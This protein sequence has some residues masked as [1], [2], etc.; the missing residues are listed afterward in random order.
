MLRVLIMALAIVLPGSGL[1]ACDNSS[2]ST[3]SDGANRVTVPALAADS[4]STPV[5]PFRMGWFFQPPQPTPQSVV[6]T[7]PVMAGFSDAILIQ[8]EVP[9]KRL[10][11][12][13]SMETIAEE[14]YDGVVKFLTGLGIHVS[15]LV[16]PLDGLDRT[17]EGSEM[18][19]SGRSLKEPEIR[20]IHEQWVK[21]LAARYKPEFLGLASEINSLAARGDPELYAAVKLMCD[22]LAPR[23]REISP[24]T[25]VFVSFQVDEAWARVPGLPSR[26]D[27][28]KLTRDF[29]IDV[30][31]LSSYPSFFF[32]DP[33][34]IPPDY[35]SRLM[36]ASGKPVLVAEG[37][38]SSDPAGK[39]ETPETL[40]AQARFMERFFVLVDSVQPELVILLLFADLDLEAWKTVAPAN[41]DPERVRP[42]ISMGLAHDDLSPKPALNIWAAVFNRPYVPGP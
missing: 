20:A 30:L 24:A 33:S 18:R 38:W 25:R 5:R 19:A 3:V 14:E 39:G 37:G 27:H 23:I 15:F 42:F 17:R 11:A 41:S 40:A 35:F 21:F 34:D 1:L 10:L 12:G 16:D 7:S 32:D 31:G 36:V 29:D 13:D 8:R 22:R 2:R 9:W 6:K 26:V 4:S 28:F